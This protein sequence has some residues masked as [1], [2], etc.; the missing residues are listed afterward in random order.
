MTQI[1]NSKQMIGLPVQFGAPSTADQALQ[2]VF[3]VLYTP[4]M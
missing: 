1:Q 4:M 2:G 3:M